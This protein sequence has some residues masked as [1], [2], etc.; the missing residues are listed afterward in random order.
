[1]AGQP[2]TLKEAIEY[3]SNPAN[4]LRY[5]LA[6][7]WP[8]GV[9]CPTCG[10]TEVHFLAKQFRWECRQKHPRR[11]F[12]AK[13]GTI[14]QD[15]RIG[16]DK[17]LCAIWMIGNCKNGV[18]PREIHS[19]LCVTRKTAGFMLQRIRTALPGAGRKFS[20]LSELG[21][22]MDRQRASALWMPLTVELLGKSNPRTRRVPSVD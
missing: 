9:T 18:S 21:T 14:F 7:R 16:L 3:F 12:S 19:S 20:D 2:Q 4:C 5:V 13:G 22:G 11:Q 6:T 10:S 1:M 8:N 15:S 17:W